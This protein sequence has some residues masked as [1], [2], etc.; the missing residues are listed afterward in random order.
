MCVLDV[1]RIVSG[2]WDKT[3]R[4]WDVNL[5]AYVKVLEGHSM[6]RTIVKSTTYI[7]PL[8]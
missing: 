2:S 7:Y 4:I 8:I 5:G 6:V 1:D 3:I